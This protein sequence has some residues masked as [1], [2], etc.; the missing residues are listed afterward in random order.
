V[1]ETTKKQLK[2]ELLEKIELLKVQVIYQQQQGN[3]SQEQYV[4]GSIDT[5]QAILD[6]YLLFI[7]LPKE[8][9]DY[10]FSECKKLYKAFMLSEYE[11]TVRIDKT[12]AIGLRETVHWL[13]RQVKDVDGKKAPMSEDDVIMS[14]GLILNKW[15]KFPNNIRDYTRLRQIN[16]NLHKIVT[17]LKNRN[18]NGNRTNSTEQRTDT[19]RQLTKAMLIGELPRDR[20]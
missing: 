11:M 17:I 13:K 15:G 2:K 20:G 4:Q 1:A 10:M 14:F 6:G 7:D 8:R 9:K 19:F 12:D 3:V 5:Y 18:R 16:R